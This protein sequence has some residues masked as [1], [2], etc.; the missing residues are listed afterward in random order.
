MDNRAIRWQLRFENYCDALK[1]L[2]EIVP[3]Y[4][5]LNELEKDGLIQRFEFCF[6]LAW[7]VMQDYLKFAGYKDIKGPRI[8]IMQMAQ[9]GLLDPF[10]WEDLLLARNELSHIYDEAKSRV[11]LDKIILDYYPAFEGFKVKMSSKL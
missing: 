9:D 11:Y 8:C 4:N 10:V 5:I 6:D 1:T 7:K 2:E 3:K